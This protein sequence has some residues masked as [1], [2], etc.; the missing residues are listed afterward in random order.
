MPAG[1]TARPLLITEARPLVDHIAQALSGVA[2]GDPRRWKD[3]S[4]RLAVVVATDDPAD[5]QRRFQRLPEIVALVSDDVGV[6]VTGLPVTLVTSSPA[7][8]G[9]AL[10][11]ATGSSEYVEA[12]GP[13]PE[14]ADEETVFRHAR[15]PSTIRPAPET[16]RGT[17]PAAAPPVLLEL[18]QIRGDLHM[19][20]TWS[21]GKDTVFEMGRA[22]RDLGYE[23]IAICDHTPNV[24]VVPGLGA[25]ALRRQAD[26][27]A[28]ANEQLIP[29]RVLRGT[30]CDILPDGT[31]DL[32][33]DILAELD[34]VEIVAPHAG[35]RAPRGQ[36]TARVTEAMRHPAV[37][38]CLSHPAGGLISL[39]ASALDLDQTIP[40][41][42]PGDGRR[43]RGQRAPE[44]ARSERGAFAS[45]EPFRQ[46]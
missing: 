9:T 36:L 39:S 46:G 20:T 12:L 28:A 15:N 8:L 37:T 1:L 4:T 45:G 24:A 29:F 44:P 16:P 3:A 19:H 2:A 41:A 43:A 40:V 7:C 38:N 21:D 35:Q 31:L 10:V 18:A 22:A 23:Y 33:D 26:E 30:E 34:W 32:P 5:A 11:R 25:E 13:L 27:I 6:T 14:A 42:T 17:S